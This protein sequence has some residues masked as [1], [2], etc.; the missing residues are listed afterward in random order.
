MGPEPRPNCTAR[1]PL[2]NLFCAMCHSMP[3]RGLECLSRKSEPPQE[4]LAGASNGGDPSVIQP[5]PESSKI[6]V[7][8]LPLQPRVHPR[9]PRHVLRKRSVV[10]D[11]AV[12]GDRLR[13]RAPVRGALPRVLDDQGPPVAHPHG[14]LLRR[15]GAEDHAAGQ[16]RARDNHA[17]AH[18]QRR[19]LGVVVV[20]DDDGCYRAGADDRSTAAWCSRSR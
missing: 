8:R 17:R 15:A 6:I 3:Q 14:P 18:G 7:R 5:G 16:R 12:F 13:V 9:P 10:H 1:L 2:G 20:V 19:G 4:P 11:D